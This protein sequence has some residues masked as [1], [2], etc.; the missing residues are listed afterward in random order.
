VL[1]GSVFSWPLCIYKGIILLFCRLRMSAS[2]YEQEQKTAA[3]EC[4]QVC[5]RMP[6]TFPLLAP[7]LLLLC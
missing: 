6:K 3:L 2:S 7:P 1:L 4:M 5:A